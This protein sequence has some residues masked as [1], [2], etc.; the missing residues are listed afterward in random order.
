MPAKVGEDGLSTR[1][2]CSEGSMEKTELEYRI[3]PRV[4]KVGVTGDDTSDV[5]GSCMSEPCELFISASSKLSLFLRSSTNCGNNNGF[6][7]VDFGCGIPCDNF[8]C[9]H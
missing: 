6:N 8:S 3:W 9:C 2:D 4:E 5:D 7:I 1:V